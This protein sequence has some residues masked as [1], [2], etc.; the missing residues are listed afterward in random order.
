MSALGLGLDLRV[1][2][3]IA[4]ELA[5]AA[6]AALRRHRAGPL[7]IGRK[8]RGEIV[9]AADLES[10][11][12]IRD[13]L[14]RAF[15]SDAV[16]SE[17][18]VDTRARLTAHRVWIVDP[19]DSTSNFAAGGDEYSVSIGLAIDGQAV[20]GAVYC[21]ARDELVAGGRGLGVTLNGRP[22]GV[23]HARHLATARL[24]VS[25]KEWQRGLADQCG[26]LSITPRASLAAKL[27]RVAA[28]LDDGVFTAVPRK[29]W[30]TCAGVAL[31][32]AAG[33]VATLLDGTPIIFNRPELKQPL[34]M[35]AAGPELHPILLR[36]LG[37][38]LPALTTSGEGTPA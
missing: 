30:G 26:G 31:V 38:R 35:L 23:S 10:D 19:L 8:A 1:E 18:T 3:S 25:R 21:P 6:G 4:T 32:L 28:G 14:A 33:G 17:E 36:W 29:E 11:R 34:G 20:L 2:L 27:A 24:A 15:A 37:R 7:E 13:G 22:V 9:T 12:I 16:Y 5:R